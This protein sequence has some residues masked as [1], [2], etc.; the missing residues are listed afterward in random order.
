[1]L[2]IPEG[3]R[4]SARV[5]VL[6]G[7][8]RLLMLRAAAPDGGRFWVAPGGG[9]HAGESFEEAAARELHEETGLR[10]PIGPC[11]WTRRHVYSWGGRAHDQYERYFV[12]RAG[13]Q[14]LAPTRADDYVD[15][16]RWW[17]ATEIARSDDEFAPRRLA[18]LLP[19]LLEGANPDSPIDSGV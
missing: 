17:S 3:A 14:P 9:L 11:V 8:G 15:G 5:L 10:A 2:V 1:M 4:P 19:P 16:H 13:E 6:G 18:E 7:R 12:A